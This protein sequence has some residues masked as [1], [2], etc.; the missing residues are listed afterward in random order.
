VKLRV[1][2]WRGARSLDSSD[3]PE[4][5][6]EAVAIVRAGLEVMLCI[7]RTSC[8]YEYLTYE[9]VYAHRWMHWNDGNRRDCPN[10]V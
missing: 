6:G 2:D 1:F 7:P 5:L 9:A 4:S 10:Y 3:L 8:G